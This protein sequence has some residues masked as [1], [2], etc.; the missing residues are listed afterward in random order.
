MYN[1]IIVVTVYYKQFMKLNIFGYTSITKKSGQSIPK[2]KPAYGGQFDG[3]I[4]D[5]LPKIVLRLISFPDIWKADIDKHFVN[6][7]TNL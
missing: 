3:A 6:C 7:S 1:G 4:Q 2:K 5:F